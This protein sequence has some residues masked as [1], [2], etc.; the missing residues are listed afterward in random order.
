MVGLNTV[1]QMTRIDGF[2]ADRCLEIVGVV[3]HGS[4]FWWNG[5]D[6]FKH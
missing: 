2:R 3:G 4:F 6:W 5:S 1:R